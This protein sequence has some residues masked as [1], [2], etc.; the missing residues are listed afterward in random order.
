MIPE[1]TL[2]RGAIGFAEGVGV[3]EVEINWNAFQPGIIIFNGRTGSGKTT[4]LEN[5]QPYPKMVTRD[6]KLQDEF[7]LKNSV[8]ENEFTLNGKRYKST[9]LLDA[10]T[11]GAN[12]Y[13]T[14]DGV[15]LCDGKK[16]TYVEAVEKVLG[17]EVIFFNTAFRGQKVTGI[18]SMKDSQ[19]R[20][21]FYEALGLN[22]YAEKL[23]PVVKEKVDYWKSELQNCEGKLSMLQGAEDYA[24]LIA[25]LTAAEERCTNKREAIA[26]Q[27]ASLEALLADRNTL[28]GKRIEL[29][30]ILAANTEITKQLEEK[31]SQ[32][33]ELTD[34]YHAKH[35]VVKKEGDALQAVL[36]R[37]KET[38][39]ARTKCEDDIA[40]R[41]TITEQLDTLRLYKKLESYE[42]EQSRLISEIKYIRDGR[43]EEITKKI[44][45]CQNILNNKEKISE[46]LYRIKAVNDAIA[47]INAALQSISNDEKALQATELTFAEEKANREKAINEVS[48]QVDGLRA[49]L[50]TMQGQLRRANNAAALIERTPCDELTGS[51]CQFLLDAYQERDGIA[52]LDA[53]IEQIEAALRGEENRLAELKAERDETTRVFTEGITDAKKQLADRRSKVEQ[54]KAKQTNDLKDLQKHDWAALEKEALEAENNIRL[55]EMDEKNEHDIALANISKHLEKIEEIQ[56]QIAPLEYFAE[57]TDQKE[58]LYI[59]ALAVANAM[60]LEQ[61]LKDI[62]A[63][64]INTAVTEAKIAANTKELAILEENHQQNLE[65]LT[66]EKERIGSSMQHVDASAL[67]ADLQR[68]NQTIDRANIKI[69]ELR[70]ALAAEEKEKVRLEAAIELANETIKNRTAELTRKSEI[71]KELLEWNFLYG[72]FDKTGIP[73]LE[74]ENAA[75]E[76]T[77]EANELLQIYEANFQIRLKTVE[78]KADKKAYKD[79]FSIEIIGE[80]RTTDSDKKSGGQKIWIDSAIEGAIFIMQNKLR[81]NIQSVFYDEKDGGFDLESAY[82]YVKVLNRMREKAGLH[83]LFLI[84]HRNEL[85]D[86]IPQQVLFRPGKISLKTGE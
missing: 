38:A 76:I 68:I 18:A 85:H 31:A 65:R 71:E 7:F 64:E 24:E 59:E 11:K 13:L 30:L 52:E 15:P 69:T 77:R 37:D 51:G 43:K 14:E 49:Q 78:L 25:E 42:K 33:A 29:D 9:I 83:F 32:I 84:T 48:K 63:A 61:K 56:L 60:E 8:R 58:A 27:V 23:V 79:V 46:A 81:N 66:V 82:A 57:E 1:K 74:L 53:A 34:D 36:D 54:D 75:P 73:C 4:L 10:L 12:Y 26:G 3:E 72:A 67:D 20:E 5:M 16:S 41:A 6:G 50:E 86:L 2:V 40:M 62:E 28:N 55:L 19:L 47:E 17:S 80:N 21:L 35:E 45:R 39:G 22:Y 70:D 44:E